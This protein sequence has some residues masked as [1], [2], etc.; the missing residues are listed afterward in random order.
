MK[1]GKMIE[2]EAVFNKNILIAVDE[3]ENASRAVSY[4]GRLLA[5]IKGFKVLILHVI[6]Q[7]DEDFFPTAAEKDTWLGQHKLKVD[8]MLDNYR[9]VLIGQG[10]APEDVSVRSTLRYC[11]SLAE[12][13][14]AERN[15]SKCHTIVVG[16]QG[17]S[18]SEEFLFGSVSSKIV[19]HA[20]NC[21]VWVVE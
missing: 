3:S 8:A 19:N 14:L 7:P 13:I 10:F 18:R 17:L 9:R 15:Q 11:P 21:T 20:R 12:C 1:E 5:G 6:R 16:R 2:I 4:V